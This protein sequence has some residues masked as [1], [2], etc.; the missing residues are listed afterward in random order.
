ME[1]TSSTRL[2]PTTLKPKSGALVLMLSPIPKSQGSG[3]QWEGGYLTQTNRLSDVIVL[4]DVLYVCGGWMGGFLRRE[5]GLVGSS[6][7]ES[8]VRLTF[9]TVF[10]WGWCVWG[11]LKATLSLCILHTL[12]FVDVYIYCC[13]F[14]L[15]FFHLKK[16]ANIYCTLSVPFEW[17]SLVFLFLAS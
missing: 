8:P 4:C 15:L 1:T 12:F 10:W 16:N 13:F 7:Q 9:L 11:C 14:F 6:L 3:N 17:S 5:G 2:N